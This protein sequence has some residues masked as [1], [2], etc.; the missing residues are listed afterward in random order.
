MNYQQLIN[1][2]VAILKDNKNKTP[3]LDCEVI[4]S[5]VLNISRE[6]LLLNLNETISEKN[7]Q[8]FNYS[9]EQ[10]KQN[11]P[12]AYI[13]GQKEFWNTNFVVNESVLIPRPDTEIL[14]EEALNALKTGKKYHI[15]DIGTGSGCILISILKERKKC[16][17]TGIDIS[18][19]ATNIAKT[20]AKIQ[21]LANR[22]KFIKSDIDNF[23][24]SKY[25]LIVSNPPYISRFTLN[26]LDEDVKGYEPLLALD[27]G[28]DGLSKIEKVIKRSSK[29]IKT[30]GKLILEIGFNQLYNVSKIIMKNGF[31]IKKITKDLSGKNRCITSVKIS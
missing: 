27:G 13:V 8:K 23:F 24:A 25:D 28:P 5:K 2:S 21:H 10:R 31:Y 15:L 14:V 16:V 18:K 4:L 7:K 11:K 29:L 20:N 26:T 6:N 17:G 30:N 19:K 22:I 12:I 3:L 1:K 9:L